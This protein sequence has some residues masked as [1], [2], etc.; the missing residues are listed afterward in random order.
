MGLWEDS[1]HYDVV[2][3]GPF[4]RFLRPAGAELV[5]G[6]PFPLPVSAGAHASQRQGIAP[7]LR[8]YPMFV[9]KWNFKKI[10]YYKQLQY[11]LNFG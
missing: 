11:C 6:G 2:R 1:A 5:S 9:I 4:H 10:Y 7:L 8:A 3:S